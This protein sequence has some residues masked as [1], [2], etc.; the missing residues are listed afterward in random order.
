MQSKKDGESKKFGLSGA[1]C[2]RH[3]LFID[4]RFVISKPGPDI[5]DVILMRN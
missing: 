2:H 5:Y 1:T 4:S 3:E